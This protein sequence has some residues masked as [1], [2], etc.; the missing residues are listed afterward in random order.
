MLVG[1]FLVFFDVLVVFGGQSEDHGFLL[2]VVVGVVYEVQPTDP[3]SHDVVS[4]QG[5][6]Q[7]DS[8]FLVQDEVV[9]PTSVVSLAYDVGVSLVVSGHIDDRVDVCEADTSDH[10]VESLLFSGEGADFGDGVQLALDSDD[11]LND[12]GEG[13]NDGINILDVA[14]ESTVGEVAADL[15]LDVVD[16]LR[17]DDLH[18]A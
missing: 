17:A 15:G 3:S 5:G 7:I 13:F 18:V 4:E 14:T 8:G 11:L 9:V 16:G 6:S 2:L 1:K 12:G 10:A